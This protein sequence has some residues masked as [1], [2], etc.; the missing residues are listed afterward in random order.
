MVISIKRYPLSNNKETQA[1]LSEEA[2]SELTSYSFVQRIIQRTRKHDNVSI[3]NPATL[4]EISVPQEL[5]RTLK[6]DVFLKCDSG[7]DDS[8]RF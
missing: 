3:L 1:T 8:D 6:G 2:V 5:K 7:P 4:K